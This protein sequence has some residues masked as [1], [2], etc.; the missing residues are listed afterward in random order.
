MACAVVCC[1]VCCCVLI[2]ERCLL[3]DVRCRCCCVVFVVCSCLLF[4]MWCALFSDCGWRGCSW[5][6][7]WLMMCVVVL[8]FVVHCL[9]RVVCSVLIACGAARC[10]CCC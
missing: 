8:V 7:F 6:V 1:L 9:L 2:V 4:D 5:S 10:W 3:F